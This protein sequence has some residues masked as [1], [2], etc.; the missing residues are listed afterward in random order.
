MSADTVNKHI[1]AALNKLGKL[2]RREAG[3]LFIEWEAEQDA[4]KGGPHSMGPHSMG[5]PPLTNIT[6]SGVVDHDANASDQRGET[7][8][9]RQAVYTLSP[10][11]DER[12]DMVPMRHSG[13]L[14]NDLS[15]ITVLS[16]VVKL[17]LAALFAVG[18][19]LSM[20][21]SLSQLAR[22]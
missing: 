12:F 21:S 18:S 2:S 13:R 4:A 8:G 16:T 14:T 10:A 9:E 22:H 19:V 3:R 6:P 15:S 5:L 1:Y 20:L 11:G 7:F 17:M